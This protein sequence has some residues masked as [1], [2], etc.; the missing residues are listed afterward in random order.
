MNQKVRL[1]SRDIETMGQILYTYFFLYFLVAGLI[2]LISMIGAI[3]LTLTLKKKSKLQILYKQVTR[4][5]DEA[6]FLIKTK[7]R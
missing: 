1:Y 2:L 7:K 3:V 5:F 6:I 4:N